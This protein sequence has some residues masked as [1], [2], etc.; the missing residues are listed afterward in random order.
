MDPLHDRVAPTRQGRVSVPLYPEGHAGAA[1]KDGGAVAATV[2]TELS[3][4]VF[5]P[6][7]SAAPLPSLGAG[8]DPCDKVILIMGAFCTR[9]MWGPLAAELAR[10][11]F[12]ALVYDHRGMAGVAGGAAGRGDA[13]GPELSARLLA[14]DA[15]AVADGAFGPVEEDGR[16]SPRPALHVIGA[17]MGGMVATEMAVL[18]ARGESAPQRGSGGWGGSSGGGGGGGHAP[19]TSRL[20][21]LTVM[22]SCRGLQPALW[23]ALGISVPRWSLEPLLRWLYPVPPPPPPPE[24]AGQA[25]ASGDGS[26]GAAADGAPA[27]SPSAT[28][29]AVAR[30]VDRLL[31]DI[32]CA[33]MLDAPYPDQ[34]RA[35]ASLRLLGAGD[36]AAE[37]AA[38]AAAAASSSGGG[39]G[40]RAP[41]PSCSPAPAHAPAPASP[42]P[43]LLTYRD[44]YRAAW[45]AE[46]HELFCF[47]DPGVG[48]G[49]ASVVMSARFP[50]RKAAAVRSS[51]APV[52]CLV[53]ERDALIAPRAQR[54]LARMLG[55]RVLS[56][57]TGHVGLGPWAGAFY[58]A[59]DE[60]L[61]AGRVAMSAATA[62][63][64]SGGGSSGGGGVS[65]K[66]TSSTGGVATATAV[67]AAAG[68]LPAAAVAPAP[69]VAVAVA[70]RA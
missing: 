49:H 12:H 8:R 53:A 38:A 45:R 58:A 20:A 57:P 27:S 9:R 65:G 16:A 29:P 68:G 15:L 10:R 36:A 64:S 63:G 6:P 19:P 40:N 30:V 61:R 67:T 69:A 60:T 44:V 35:A 7:A 66:G 22:V 17:S 34:R 54:E 41:A 18:L 1:A 31:R 56:V 70:V 3:F 33:R 62:R 2:S 46:F 14:A 11:G 55:A 32:V 5:S 24:R 26:G 39:D 51:G 50:Q 4:E 47:A 37:A 59:L 13:P 21:S 52:L 42:P 43:P 28:C 48:A 25:G 23:R